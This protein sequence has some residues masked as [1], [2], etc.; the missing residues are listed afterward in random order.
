L[1]CKLKIKKILQSKGHCSCHKSIHLASLLCSDI[2]DIRYSAV[3]LM[4][5]ATLLWHWWHSLLC[6]DIDE[7]AQKLNILPRGG[8]KTWAQLEHCDG[9]L[10][11]S[12]SQELGPVGRKTWACWWTIH[13]SVTP[14]QEHRDVGPVWTLMVPL[15]SP[16]TSSLLQEGTVQWCFFDKWKILLNWIFLNDLYSSAD[17]LN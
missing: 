13:S 10:T 17:A 5:F 11:V 6:C 9:S 14:D 4:T 7:T 12:C 2:D 3:T 1:F 8:A 15:L 16:L